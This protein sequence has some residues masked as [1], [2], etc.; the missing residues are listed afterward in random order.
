MYPFQ[1]EIFRQDLYFMEPIRHTWLN[2]LV[3]ELLQH[4]AH[5]LYKSYQKLRKLI[6]TS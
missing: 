3:V 1:S 5:A 6:D 4:G 2:K